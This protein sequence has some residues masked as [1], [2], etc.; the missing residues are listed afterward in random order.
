MIVGPN[1]Y[2]AAHA[3][4][5]CPHCG[6]PLQPIQDGDRPRLHCPHDDWTWYPSPAV[7]STVVVELPSG[8]LLLRRAIPPDIGIW[9]LPIGHVEYGER[10]DEAAHREVWEETGLRLS[11][12]EFLDIEFGQSRSDP[13]LHYHVYCYAATCDTDAVQLNDEN[14]G[15]QILPFESIPPLKWRSQRR[16]LAAWSARRA[17]QPWQPTQAWE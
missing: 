12:L 7:A 13:R 1:D 15:V 5:F 17:G 10:P 9:H 16:A 11:Q 14:D 3:Y 6:N 8:I 2:P 4:R